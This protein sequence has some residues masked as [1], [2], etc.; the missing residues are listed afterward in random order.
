MRGLVAIF[1]AIGCAV[2]AAQQAAPTV[3]VASIKRTVNGFITGQGAARV[4]WEPGGLFRISDGSVSVLLY[5]AY[6]DVVDIV[7]LSGWAVSDHFDIQIK[8]TREAAAAD[9]SEDALRQVLADRFKLTARVERQERPTYALRLA[10]TDGALGRNLRRA[11]VDCGTFFKLPDDQRAAVPAP[12]SGGP[13]CG[14]MVSSARILSGGT[15]MIRLAGN[16]RSSAGREV[17]DETGLTGDY[18]FALEFGGDV[19]VFTAVREQLGLT[20]EPSRSPLPV[21]IVDRIEYPTP[22]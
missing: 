16:L 11:P 1:M 13:R 10:R 9:R 19:S 21:L 5:S 18:E 20:L 15:T 3:E 6:P 14:M 2:V 7:G 17:I 4:G 12:G 22:D 8:A